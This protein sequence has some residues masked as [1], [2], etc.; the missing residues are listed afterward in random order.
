MDNGKG[1]FVPIS[2]EKFEE[3]IKTTAPMVF[4]VGEIID[5]RGSR[6]RLDRIYKN[7]IIFRLLPSNKKG[8]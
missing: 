2:S 7:K 6:L 1:N 4:R 5:I 8:L 3:Q